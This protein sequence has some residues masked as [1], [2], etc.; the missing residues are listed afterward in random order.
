MHNICK[1]LVVALALVLCLSFAACEF[2]PL[3]QPNETTP[4]VTTPN[5][6]TPAVTTP[7]ETTPEETTPEETTPEETTPEETE[8]DFSNTPD[9]D[10]TKRY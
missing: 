9:P 3:P 7:N 4:A 1:L 8:P 10:G 2:F 5:E 6:T